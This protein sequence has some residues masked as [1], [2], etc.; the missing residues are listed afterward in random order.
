MLFYWNVSL[1]KLNLVQW[2]LLYQK[3]HFRRLILLTC[4]DKLYFIINEY[5][6]TYF[7]S[8]SIMN[9]SL[10]AYFRYFGFYKIHFL[11]QLVKSFMIFFTNFLW[12]QQWLYHSI[13]FL[14]NLQFPEKLKG[15]TFHVKFNLKVKFHSVKQS[16]FSMIGSFD[17][18]WG[19]RLPL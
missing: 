12:I 8:T 13:K 14:R 10:F 19:M 5:S 3:T 9:S 15:L 11:I 16:K 1:W 7:S 17:Q 4:H 2:V 18:V 6:I